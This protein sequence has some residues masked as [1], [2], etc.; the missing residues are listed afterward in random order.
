MS[1]QTLVQKIESRDCVLGVIGLGYVGLPVAC[2]FARAGFQVI[3]LDIK[4]ER[5]DKINAGINPIEGVEPGLAELLLEVTSSGRLVATTE[6][7]RLHIVDVVTI[8]VETPVDEEHKPRYEA[9][10]A[11]C[12]SLGQVLKPGA[13]VI[14][15]STVTPGTTLNLARNLIEVASG[16]VCDVGQNNTA[17]EGVFH[18]GACPERVMPGRLLQNLRNVSRVCGGST[19]EVA[20]AM[21]SL[22]RTIIPSADL[23]PS[24]CLTAEL[25]KTT[26]NAYRDVNIAFA[27]EVALI[28][29]AAGGDVWKVRELVNK[30]PGRNMLLPGAGVGGHCIP[31]DPWL[32]ASA[33]NHSIDVRLIPA[34][35]AVN[36]SMPAH[37]AKLIERALSGQGKSLHGARVLVLGYSYLEDSDDTRH[38]PSEALVQILK[39]K[40][41]DVVVHDPWIEQFQGDV[42]TLAQGSDAIALMVKHSAYL[43]L[44]FDRLLTNL[45]D[46]IVVDGRQAIRDGLSENFQNRAFLVGVGQ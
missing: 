16:Y 37:M 43:Q 1:N 4:S 2:E 31:K 32:L 14:I 44:D 23:D 26:E 45:P 28:C 42:E 33:A 6:Y 39:E 46:L 9:L 29:E 8:N 10:R 3:G 34:A 27:N 41:A 38:S 24:D 11:A 7:S 36:E 13:L 12:N 5:V 18:I 17:D 35:R 19:P 20:R 40:S 21:T 30:S 22:Y 15:E 25:V